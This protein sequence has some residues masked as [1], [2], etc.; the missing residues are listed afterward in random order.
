[1]WHDRLDAEAWWANLTVSNAAVAVVVS[2]VGEI[3]RREQLREPSRFDCEA[4]AGTV[5]GENNKQNVLLGVHPIGCS[6]QCHG[7]ALDRCAS[8]FF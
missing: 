1:M 8:A 6:L 2:H 7:Q 5:R 4:G 3:K